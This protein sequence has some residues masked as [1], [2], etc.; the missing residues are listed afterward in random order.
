[1]LNPDKVLVKFLKCEMKGGSQVV[2]FFI[3]IGVFI[4]L[5]FELDR[6]SMI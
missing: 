5:V 3:I 6:Q 4:D 2:C 1:M